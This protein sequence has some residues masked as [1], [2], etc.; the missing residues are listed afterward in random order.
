MAAD[1]LLIFTELPVAASTRHS[2]VPPL[3]NDD[4]EELYDACLR[5]VIALAARERGRLE[6]WFSGGKRARKYFERE[7]PHLEHHAQNDGSPGERLADA[8]ERSFRDGAERVVV[9]GSN[10]PTVPDTMLTSAFHDLHD[11]DAILGPAVDGRYFLTGLRTAA[12]PRARSILVEAPEPSSGPWEAALA[13]AAKNG[14][15][16]RIL[17]G[18]YQIGGPDDL[19]RAR[20]HA[21]PESH[22]GR[23]LAGPGAALFMP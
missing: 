7:F 20:E 5:D 9:L 23:W 4:A 15:D 10:A 14:L 22:L 16:V 17:P 19:R 18:W 12:W 2:L 8:F 21:L 3:S 11:A 6:L 1:R 13:A